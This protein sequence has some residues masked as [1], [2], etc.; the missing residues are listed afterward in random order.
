M[1]QVFYWQ[2]EKAP[3]YAVFRASKTGKIVKISE[4]S[5]ISKMGLHKPSNNAGFRA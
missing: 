4:K 5:A 1:K 2:I 3:F